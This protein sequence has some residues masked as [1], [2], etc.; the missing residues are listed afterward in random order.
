MKKRHLPKWLV[1]TLAVIAG[2]I[3]LSILNGIFTDIREG[4]GAQKQTFGV[5]SGSADVA[6]NRTAAMDMLMMDEDG[7]EMMKEM[8]SAPSPSMPP[9]AGGSAAVDLDGESVTPRIIKNGDL[10]LR[11][12]DASETM[13]S[14]NTLVSGKSGFVESSSISDSGEGPR[15]AHMTLRVPVES[16]EGIIGELKGFATLVLHESTGGQDV[17][18]EFIDLEANL[19]NAQAEEE[20][21]RAI[22]NRSGS[23]EEVLMV[24]RQLAEVRGRIERFEARKRYLENRTDLATL[25]LTLTEETRIELPTET[26]RPFEVVKQ[27]VR[28][29]ILGLQGFVDFLIQ[30]VIGVIGL[31]I[32]V[33]A[34][35][36]LVLWLGWKLVKRIMKKM[37]K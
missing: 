30:F 29:L 24:T 5:S 21:Y 27:S 6:G 20:S 19:R 3:I 35:T 13:D 7:G 26:W 25:Q 12:E 18:T 37:K 34:F 22:L 32:P 16:F 11:V 4:E 15:T 17:T 8:E 28:N 36:A 10:R 14:V 9:M 33:A 23:I 1:I 31:L 2:L